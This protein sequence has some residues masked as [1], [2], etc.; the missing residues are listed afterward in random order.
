V[1]LIDFWASWCAPCLI[2]FP[3]MLALAN[4]YPDQLVWLA[5][6]VDSSQDALTNFTGQYPPPPAN[7]L[8]IWD[9]KKAIAQ[10]LF[11][12]IRYPET[13]LIGPDFKMHRKIVGDTD[14]TGAE[15]EAEL[16]ALFATVP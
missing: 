3:K 15:M 2:E 11:Q 1:V 5:V 6:S 4:Q 14:W 9:S 16:K 10:D 13:I 7:A 8:M 12:S